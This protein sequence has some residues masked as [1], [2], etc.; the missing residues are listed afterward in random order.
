MIILSMATLPSLHTADMANYNY[1]CEDG[2]S[3]GFRIEGF[4]V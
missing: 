2:C 3:L 1:S 4:R